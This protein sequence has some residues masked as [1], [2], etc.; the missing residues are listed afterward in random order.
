MLSGLES[1]GVQIL[2]GLLPPY[3]YAYLQIYLSTSTI[4]STL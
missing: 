1:K 3:I 4:K 2:Y